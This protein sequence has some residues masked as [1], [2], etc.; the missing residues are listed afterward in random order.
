[1]SAWLVA[2]GQA[3][4][5]KSQPS[6]DRGGVGET[7]LHTQL[8]SCPPCGLHASLLLADA[9]SAIAS[10]PGRPPTPLRMSAST[11][12][13]AQA[14]DRA[15]AHSRCR[16]C[17]WLRGITWVPEAVK[18]ADPVTAAAIGD[19]ERCG[20]IRRCRTAMRLCRRSAGIRAPLRM[21]TASHIVQFDAAEGTVAIAIGRPSAPEWRR[22]VG[23][24][25]RRR[26]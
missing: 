7:Y 4:L 19:H 9:E 16:G 17:G 21:A 15:A 12:P 6:L 23:G 13:Q 22:A 18:L 20:G 8:S 3:L 14:V 26:C 10:P 11:T 2:L 24:S 25:D 5:Q 1:M